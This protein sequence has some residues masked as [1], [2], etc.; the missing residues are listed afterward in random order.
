M[1]WQQGGNMI[2][3]PRGKAVKEAINPVR[4]DWLEALEKLHGGRF[5]G[6]LHCSA[7]S[8]AGLVLF[9][10]G[11]LSLARFSCGAGRQDG[12]PALSRL[13]ALA[14]SGA[15]SLS[16]FRLTPALAGRV[17]D[18]LAGEFLYRGQDREILDIPYLLGQLREECFNGGLLVRA[19]ER[20]ALI[21]YQAGVPLGFFHDGAQELAEQ[22]E[23]NA[24]VAWL[25]GA[26]ID[27]IRADWSTASERPDLLQDIDLLQI[28]Q[29]ALMAAGPGREAAEL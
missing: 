7:G 27:V 3:L 10:Q 6:Y 26:K 17:H 1:G 8:N 13:F 19:A 12:A 25:P 2:Q 24:S 18:L 29:E 4:M 11:A 22:A 23:L 14:L 21:F 20:A 16:I 5:S 28:W 15:A 9:V